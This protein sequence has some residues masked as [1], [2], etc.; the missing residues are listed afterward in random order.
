VRAAEVNSLLSAA[1]LRGNLIAR[2][3]FDALPIPFRAV[4]TDLRDR[5]AVVLRQG[6]LARAVRASIAIPLVF[7]PESIGTRVL[8]D[9]GLSA[10]IP[11]AIAH[12][13][14]AVRVIVSDATERG[15]DSLDLFSPLALADR[16]L[17][18]LFEQNA[19][20]VRAGDLVIRPEVEGFTSLDFSTDRVA[21]LIEAGKAAARLALADAPCLPHAPPTTH[22]L[23]TVLDTVITAGATPAERRAMLRL[24][25]VERGQRLDLVRLRSRVR[26]L[27]ASDAF[28]AIWLNPAGSGDTVRFELTPLR[29][30]R[31]AAGLG[32]AYDNEL[33]GRMWIGIVDRN[34]FR[35]ALDGSAALFLGELRRELAVGFRRPYQLT[36]RL[37]TPTLTA[38][39]ATE[40]VRRF[41]LLREEA[42]SLDTREARIFAGLERSLGRGWVATLGASAIAWRE[43][44]LDGAHAAGGMAQVA[45]TDRSSRQSVFGQ[46]ELT[47][48]VARVAVEASP[49]IHFGLFDVRPVVRIG[50]GR[51]LPLQYR[52]QLGG[53]DGFPGLHIG[54][55][56]GSRE[57]M[58]GV[59]FTIPLKGAVVLVAEGAAGRSASGGPLLD[60]EG[61]IAGARAGIGADTPIG[62]M[63][64]DYGFAS[65]GREALRVRLGRWF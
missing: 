42:T 20:S 50:W 58:A 25:G 54:E 61:W 5:S 32:L 63:R 40:S 27:A 15:Q 65:G 45:H 9:G 47:P 38:E 21:Q 12:E 52:F 28:D 57:A 51:R 8:A 2:G 34:L 37:V 14:G 16:L 44:G 43:P 11:I 48:T 46:A 23:P 29:A 7:P 18:F 59:A 26:G 4:A 36:G 53:T 35:L 55:L 49:S 30:A 56:R 13:A 60:S 3:N 1:L 10:N 31:R 17:G 22:T 24:L 6:D 41:D 33:G 62:P 19:D 39:I 64:F